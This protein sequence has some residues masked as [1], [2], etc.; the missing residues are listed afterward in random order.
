LSVPG[1][2]SVHCPWCS[3]WWDLQ[4]SD[5]ATAAAAAAGSAA[6]DTPSQIVTATAAGGRAEA[7]V[8]HAG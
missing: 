6:G 1:F 7:A 5:T 8:G 2:L 4:S 3:S